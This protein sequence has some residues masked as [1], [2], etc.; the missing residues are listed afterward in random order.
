MFANVI[1]KQGAEND[2]RDH[3]VCTAS[4]SSASNNTGL[5]SVSAAF[6]IPQSRHGRANRCPQV[7]QTAAPAPAYTKSL[8][9]GLG[10]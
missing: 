4:C 7:W 5:C 9:P 6:K 2:L 10:K 8:A 1:A 3:A